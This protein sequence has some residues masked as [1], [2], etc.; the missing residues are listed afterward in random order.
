MHTGWHCFGVVPWLKAAASLPAE[1]SVALSRMSRS[2]GSGKPVIAIL[3]LDHIANFD[4]FD[5]LLQEESADVVFVKAGERIPDHASLVIIPGSKTTI[6]DLD[7]LRRYGWDRQIDRH[8]G[9]GGHV[10]GICGGFQ[11]LGKSVTD[12]LGIEGPART[13]AGLGLLDVATEMRVEKTVR[14]SAASSALFDAPL[15][16]YEIHLGETVGPDCIKPFAYF[17]NKPEG[18]VSTSGRVYG[19][20]LHGLFAN[21]QFRRQFLQSMGMTAGAGSHVEKVDAA[22]DDIA[23]ELE[24]LGLGEIISRAR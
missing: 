23:A 20:Y 4:D 17:G 11:M 18:A 12:P 14:L 9:D 24:A 8:V 13:V 3:E 22:L 15:E 2:A 1:D 10:L 6:S 16:G 5:A 19:T 7:A 21:D